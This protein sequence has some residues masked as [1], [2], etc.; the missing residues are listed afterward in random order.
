[1][2]VTPAAFTVFLHVFIGK[3]IYILLTIIFFILLLFHF[4][5][6]IEYVCPR[7]ASRE[8]QKCTHAKCRWAGRKT[9]DGYREKGI[10]LLT[11]KKAGIWFWENNIRNKDWSFPYRNSGFRHSDA[12][13]EKFGQRCNINAPST[14]RSVLRKSLGG[15]NLNWGDN[16]DKS[17]LLVYPDQGGGRRTP[18]PLHPNSL[19]LWA[20]HWKVQLQ[21]FCAF[22]SGPWKFAKI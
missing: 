18:L 5:D 8:Y 10:S 11:E 12:T 19:R 2:S 7:S 22:N 17:F 14:T 20:R 3:A 16:V 21:N 15:A 9:G 6:D 13:G 4:A 1:M